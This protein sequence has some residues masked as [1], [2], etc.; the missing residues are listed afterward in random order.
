MFA[1]G[2]G[3]FVTMSAAAVREPAGKWLAFL[4]PAF[5]YYGTRASVNR[6]SF[7]GG[8]RSSSSI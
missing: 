5:S 3:A 8:R 6:L 2:G 4:K 1:F 7:A